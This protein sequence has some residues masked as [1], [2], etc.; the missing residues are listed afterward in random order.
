[1]IDCYH[2]NCFF[3]K[4]LW[5]FNSGEEIQT[6]LRRRKKGDGGLHW[7]TE[8]KSPGLGPAPGVLGSRSQPMSPGLCFS[9]PFSI[10]SSGRG[11]IISSPNPTERASPTP[12]LS[13]QK[14]QG[15]QENPEG[16]AWIL[17]PP[18]PSGSRSKGRRPSLCNQ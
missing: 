8:L 2:W 9:G 18:N 6:N 14:V 12:P 4:L 13:P 16:L 17:G 15:P 5:G 11:N 3:S 7:L 1:M 10:S